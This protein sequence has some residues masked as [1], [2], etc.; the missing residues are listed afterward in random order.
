[1][2][3]APFTIPAS[4]RASRRR[5]R[6]HRVA[7]GSCRPALTGFM[8]VLSLQS[9]PRA[10]GVASNLPRQVTSALVKAAQ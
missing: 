6:G 2:V 1:M 10:P 8:A 5:L 3:P 9:G 7:V 4:G